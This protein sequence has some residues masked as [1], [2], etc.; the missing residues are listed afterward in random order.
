MTPLC[1]KAARNV[2]T[3]RPGLPALVVSK[4]DVSVHGEDRE[5]EDHELL[6]F[7][8]LHH[9]ISGRSIEMATDL[10]LQPFLQR[11]SL[12][13]GADSVK[14][15]VEEHCGHLA[16]DY[17]IGA[18]QPIARSKHKR[19]CASVLKETHGHEFC[20]LDFVLTLPLFETE[21]ITKQ[22]DR[23]ARC[24]PEL[25]AAVFRRP[26][27]LA[28]AVETGFDL[29]KEFDGRPMKA[30]E[31]RTG[32]LHFPGRPDAYTIVGSGERRKLRKEVV[33][34]N[35]LIDC[36]L[37]ECEIAAEALI[38]CKLTACSGTSQS[39][40]NCRLRDSD[41]LTQTWICNLEE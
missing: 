35:V 6:H 37:N 24:A 7:V 30:L 31:Q 8:L 25:Q 29:E 19:V 39:L 22:I 11:R 40:I 21:V 34:T 15:S 27:M 38:R 20:D 41:V 12:P 13:D 16:A 10:A 23:L 17:S 32:L 36:T 5:A 28:W 3:T 4:H 18:D 1:L 33:R 26:A 2:V 14:R 9:R